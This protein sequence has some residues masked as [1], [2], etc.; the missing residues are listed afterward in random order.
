MTYLLRRLVHLFLLLVGV[1]LLSFAFLAL[2]PGSFLDEMR[3]DPQVSPATVAALHLQYGLDRPVYVRYLRWI[4]ALL[5][6]DLGHSFAYNQPTSVLLLPRA[7]NTLALTATA[8]AIAWLIALPLGIWAAA[9]PKG[10]V[11]RT[12]SFS[13]ATIL[14]I[15]DLLLILCLLLLAVKTNFLPTGGMRSVD[16]DSSD[17]VHQLKD[18]AIHFFL[19]LVALVL[20]ILPTLLRHVRDAVAKSLHEPFLVAATG[21][22]IPKLRLLLRYAFPMAANP[23]ISLFGFSVGALLSTSLL[24][25][26]VLSWPGLGPMLLEAILARDIYLVI[27]AIMFSSLF[28]VGGT[29]ISDLML[30]WHDPRIRIGNRV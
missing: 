15:P 17:F 12:M 29:L 16:F 1:S 27:G 14:G 8:T 20:G 25:E 10:F 24:I 26:V 7:R 30:Y 23:L 19:P 4:K 9:Y 3:L 21:H 2:A 13:A 22:G 11:D 18:L 5:H 6:G 28:L